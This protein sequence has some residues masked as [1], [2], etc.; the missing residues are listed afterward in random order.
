MKNT[1]LV[2]RNYLVCDK[3]VK[4]KNFAHLAVK[5]LNKYAVEVDKPEL[6]TEE[7]I[8]QISRFYGDYIPKSFY[9]NPQDITHYSCEEL[10]IEQM[11]SYFTITA[12]GTFTTDKEVYKRKELFE[13]V[14]PVTSV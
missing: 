11:V 12:N 10:W 7:H 2:K 4:S 8:K 9:E 6:L 3:N 14:L 13:K 5:L 1:I